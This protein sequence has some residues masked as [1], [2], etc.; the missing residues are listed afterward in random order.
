[1]S[2][3]Q[4]IKHNLEQYKKRAKD[5]LKAYQ[6]GDRE[7]IALVC[8]HVPRLDETTDSQSEIVLTEAQ[9]VIACQHLFKDWNWLRAVST[10]DCGLLIH[11]RNRELMTLLRETDARDL[12]I[13]LSQFSDALRERFLDCVSER[14]RG[15][16]IEEMSFL[17]PLSAEQ[18]EDSQ[19]RLMLNA[20]AL[21][22]AGQLTWP[23]DKEELTA[24]HEEKLSV[25]GLFP[26]LVALAA[27]PLEEMSLDEIIKLWRDIADLA[28]R[29]GIM[30]LD[31][32]DASPLVREAL[33][34]M[35]DGTEPPL[36]E[37][38]LETRS[39]HALLGG[40][41]IRCKMVIGALLAILSGDNPRIVH[42][43][44]LTFFVDYRTPVSGAERPQQRETQEIQARL[45][46]RLQQ[47]LAEMDY[48]EIAALFTDMA[49]LRRQV[50]FAPLHALVEKANYPL[51]RLGLERI[52]AGDAPQQIIAVLKEQ[53]KR[54][55]QE[56]RVRYRA[57]IAGAM[58]VQSGMNPQET[59]RHVREASAQN[60]WI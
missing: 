8:K 54:E 27:K 34:L 48:G 24:E 25:D 16:L 17:G 49:Y 39:R 46:K 22:A 13:S 42:H 10:L 57:V 12:A 2:V 23:N 33:I 31:A 52:A 45:D 43:K 14:S 56:A 18:V 9:H 5:L 11:C 44:L 26:N 59:E 20:A 29:E 7:A 35:V 3:Q 28:R 51:M 53:M 6:S 55:L 47:N 50:G 15:F 58:A 1:M 60:E 40:Q 19:R 38:L 21:A 36:I 4:I 37:D 30:A 32:I 41:E